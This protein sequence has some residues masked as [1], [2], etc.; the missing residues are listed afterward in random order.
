MNVSEALVS[1]LRDWNCRYVF[2][3]SGANIEHLHDAIHRLGGDNL[4]SVMAKSEIGAA[5]MA[6][7]RAR[8][9]GLTREDGHYRV[10]RLRVREGRR[11]PRRLEAAA[12]V[13]GH[14]PGVEDREEQRRGDAA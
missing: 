11:E 6:D 9:A 14:E 3:V 1:A 7:A 13:L 10:A 2:G 12:R 4:Q 8:T 5:M